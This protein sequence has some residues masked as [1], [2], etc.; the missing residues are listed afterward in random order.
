LAFVHILNPQVF[1]ETLYFHRFG[2][3]L[4][5]QAVIQVSDDQFI[6]Q[7]P[8]QVQQAHAIWPA[9][10]RHERG[11]LVIQVAVGLQREF[12]TIVHIKM[13]IIGFGYDV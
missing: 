4:W 10:N 12:D 11:T 7:T 2:G 13:I 8:Q 6:T 5:S 1:C 9:R 3:R